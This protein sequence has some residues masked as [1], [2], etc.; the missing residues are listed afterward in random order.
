MH[1]LIASANRPGRLGKLIEPGINVEERK[2][3]HDKIF[4]MVFLRNESFD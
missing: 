3:S 4:G 2:R 1:R